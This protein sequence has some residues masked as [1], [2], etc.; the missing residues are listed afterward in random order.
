MTISILSLLAKTILHLERDILLGLFDS[1]TKVIMGK[2]LPLFLPDLTSKFSS[3]ISTQ[4]LHSCLKPHRSLTS[5]FTS[6]WKRLLHVFLIF[7]CLGYMNPAN[8]A[9]IKAL[10]V[11]PDNLAN[12]ENFI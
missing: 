10:K 5:S 6:I 3:F 4:C 2:D 11:M 9:F 7:F 12:R 8:S 1:L